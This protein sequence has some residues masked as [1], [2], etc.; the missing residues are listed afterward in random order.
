MAG[1]EVCDAPLRGQEPAQVNAQRRETVCATR[2]CAPDASAQQDPQSLHRRSAVFAP[3]F[4]VH[5][6]HHRGPPS[7]LSETWAPA[8]GRERERRG[9]RRGGGGGRG[10][11]RERGALRKEGGQS[12]CLTRLPRGAP[13]QGSGRGRGCPRLRVLCANSKSLAHSTLRSEYCVPSFF[14]GELID[15]TRQGQA[16]ED[17]KRD[18]QVRLGAF[19]QK[20]ATDCGAVKRDAFPDR[21]WHAASVS[22]LAKTVLHVGEKR[23]CIRARS[24]SLSGAEAKRQ[25]ARVKPGIEFEIRPALRAQIS[26]LFF[27]VLFSGFLGSSLMSM[28]STWAREPTF[29]TRQH[30]KQSECAVAVPDSA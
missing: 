20:S 6:H 12:W 29:S 24:L 15:R 2:A 23:V 3:E 19:A 1:N 28:I 30:S 27:S 10:R 22:D 8:P 4:G 14:L 13:T 11:G 26:I 5:V 17:E 7:F 9:G 18:P 16:V 25:P 21:R